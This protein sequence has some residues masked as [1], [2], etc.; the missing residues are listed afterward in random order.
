LYAR[1]SAPFGS[2]VTTGGLATLTA[3]VESTIIV[4]YNCAS[5]KTSASRQPDGV[6]DS[7]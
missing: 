4:V 6:H 1:R 3:Y 2:R 5:L 7:V